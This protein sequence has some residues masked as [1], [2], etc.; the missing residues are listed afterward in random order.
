MRWSQ[1][2]PGHRQNAR[3]LGER[4]RGLTLSEMKPSLEAGKK[5]NRLLI[6]IAHSQETEGVTVATYGETT[7][8]PAFYTPKSGF[9]VR[10][11]CLTRFVNARR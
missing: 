8:F 2:Y 1:K 9:Q 3:I 6:S 10:Q 5:R 7:D 11:P 4:R